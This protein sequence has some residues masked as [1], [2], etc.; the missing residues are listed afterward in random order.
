MARPKVK[1]NPS[2]PA[3]RE[4]TRIGLDESLLRRSVRAKEPRSSTRA[5]RTL[6]RSNH[7]KHS[8]LSNRLLPRWGLIGNALDPAVAVA[9]KHWVR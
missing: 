6:P 8:Q 1:R 9:Y 4:F 2:R 5:K 7:G 3:P